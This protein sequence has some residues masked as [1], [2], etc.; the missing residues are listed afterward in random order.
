M[1]FQRGERKRE[2]GAYDLIFHILQ[3]HEKS[4]FWIRHILD[5]YQSSI[6][7]RLPKYLGTKFF[8][9]GMWM[10]SGWIG[11][12]VLISTPAEVSAI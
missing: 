11:Q 1:V 3:H 9:S 6:S 2:A 12:S 10:L 8:F 5:Q 7:T 4:R